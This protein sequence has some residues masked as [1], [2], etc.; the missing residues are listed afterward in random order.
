VKVTRIKE[1]RAAIVRRRA[2][3]R[4]GM[5][6]MLFEINQQLALSDIRPIKFTPE[7]FEYTAII[8]EGGRRDACEFEKLEA[9]IAKALFD[10]FEERA[11][12]ARA[13]RKKLRGFLKVR[14]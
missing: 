3:I 11:D 7:F 9:M 4:R 5:K 6:I 2:A 10:E 12:A 8:A 14:S 13:A 1:K